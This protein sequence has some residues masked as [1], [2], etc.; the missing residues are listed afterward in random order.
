MSSTVSELEEA[1][2]L[3]VRLD[4]LAKQA[5]L[6]SPNLP[7]SGDEIA[8]DQLAV[9]GRL[10]VILARYMDRAQTTIKWLTVV[11]TVL[12]ALLVVDALVRL[13]QHL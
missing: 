6:P 10:L 3:V 8:I 1:S 2:K 4:E 13:F 11:L 7:R 9:F 12:T 5:K